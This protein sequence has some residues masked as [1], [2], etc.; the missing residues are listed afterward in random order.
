MGPRHL[1]LLG[2]MH[3]YRGVPP[4]NRLKLPVHPVTCL[5]EIARPAPGRPAA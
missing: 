2:V 1:D 5:A 4:N 3:P